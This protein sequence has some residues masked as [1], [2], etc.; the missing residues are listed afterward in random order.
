M[1]CK[2][3]T[4]VIG[5]KGLPRKPAAKLPNAQVCQNPADSADLCAHT[6]RLQQ[7]LAELQGQ[8]CEPDVKAHD[9]FIH[10][11]RLFVALSQ[12][13]L[14]STRQEAITTVTEILT[15]FIGTE[16]FACLTFRDDRKKLKCL[17]SMG[18]DDD[19]I[20]ALELASEE[21]ASLLRSETQFGMSACAGYSFSDLVAAVPLRWKNELYGLIVILALL[22]QKNSLE[23][24]DY[25]LCDLLSEHA[26]ACFSR[27]V[28]AT[29]GVTQ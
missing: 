25:A 10:T 4:R 23:L 8:Q 14:A 19:R 20:A 21:M 27:D 3:T 29:G 12:M 7:R 18:V 9:E 5:P 16:Q 22:P 11:S 28:I 2:K 15:N 6:K 13:N 26:A 24:W 17:F 1:R